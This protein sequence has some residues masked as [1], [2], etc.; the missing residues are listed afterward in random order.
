MST[1]PPPSTKKF[2][3]NSLEAKV[4]S[5]AESLKEFLPVPNDRNR[6]GYNL[7][8]Y[9]TGEGD[10]PEVVV[11]NLKLT[12]QNISKEELVLKI[13]EGLNLINR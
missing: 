5:I 12:I 6:L 13:K 8:L 9:L 1:Q 3:E 7:Y 11:N 4:Y 2:P 10:N